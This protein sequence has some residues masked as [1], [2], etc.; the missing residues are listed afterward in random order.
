MMNTFPNYSA[1]RRL[2]LMLL[3][4]LP[5]AAAALEPRSFA[6]P[7]AAME[8]LIAAL[9]ANDD[10]ALTTLFGDKHKDVVTTGDRAVDAV[11]RAKA[12]AALASFRAG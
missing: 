12:A 4:A 3:L 2:A 8:A 10:A 7:E 9:K 11:E 5:L 6:T 1:L